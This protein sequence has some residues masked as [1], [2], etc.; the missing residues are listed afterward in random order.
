MS[1]F[2]SLR[3]S[4]AYLLCFTSL[5]LLKLDIVFCSL[6]E[7][8]IYM[9]PPG[10]METYRKSIESHLAEVEVYILVI[11]VFAIGD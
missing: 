11:D 4:F 9:V 5:F 2:D 10:A 8:L 3:T 1:E 7:N 6:Q